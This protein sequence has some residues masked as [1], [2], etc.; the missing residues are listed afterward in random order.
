MTRAAPDGFIA[1]DM[2][3]ASFGNSDSWYQLVGPLYFGT[4]NKPGDVRLCFYSDPKY[5]SSMSRVHGGMIASF[6]DYLLFNAA[7][8][9]WPGSPLATISL[10]VN[11][12]T[13]CDPGVWVM[14]HA[15]AV[16]SGRNIAF[17]SGEVRA[18]EKV[19]AHATGTFRK[20]G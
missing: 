5:I 1:D 9:T 7:S 17:T 6:F 16:H 18:E 10:N 2:V 13:A 14:G 15:S 4:D 3:A 20:L 19:I 8:S 11:Y 12:V